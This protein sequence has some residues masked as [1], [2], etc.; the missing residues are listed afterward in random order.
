MSKGKK[1]QQGGRERQV[2]VDLSDARE[3]VI[4]LG[5]DN[6]LRLEKLTKEDTKLLAPDADIT[7]QS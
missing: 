5:E 7:A 3:I 2:V 6:Y 1:V 4:K